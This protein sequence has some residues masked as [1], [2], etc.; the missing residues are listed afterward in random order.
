M[1]KNNRLWI[2]TF[3]FALIFSCNVFAS[4]EN[5]MAYSNFN[6]NTSEVRLQCGQSTT[7]VKFVS[8]DN[9]PLP[10][11]IYFVS[12][13]PY[14]ITVDKNLKI[15]ANGE[16]GTCYI[17]VFDKNGY[18]GRKIAVVVL[19][20][21][22]K[23]TALTL[24]QKSVTLKKGEKFTLSPQLTPITSQ[25]AV[26]Y[27][28][29]DKK[30]ATVSKKGVIVAKKTGTAKITVKSGTKKAIFTVKVA[31]TRAE[32]ITNVPATKTLK[33]GKSYTLKPKTVPAKTD[34][35]ITY[36]SSNKKVATVS[37]KGKVVAKK[38]GKATITV[39]CGKVSVKCKVTVK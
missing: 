28:S 10:S 32:Q 24:P 15:T 3:F 31:K 11:D 19:R 36:K 35:T 8:N 14:L 30:I 25:D 18:T 38:K 23:T 16:T 20:S 37:N 26:T 29:S 1:K 34:D 27:T 5:I 4:D 9:T 17:G 2:F 6:F 7:A 33:K 39:K 13:V 21:P 22:V 12:A